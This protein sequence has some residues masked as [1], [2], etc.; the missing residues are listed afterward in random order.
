MSQKNR[1]NCP[2]QYDSQAVPPKYHVYTTSSSITAVVDIDIDLK[3]PHLSVEV[4]TSES[5]DSSNSSVNEE[6]TFLRT[7][8]DENY[9]PIEKYEGRH[10]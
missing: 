7:K 9:T 3:L 2:K 5:L 8:G 4:K 6:H 1:W 10:R